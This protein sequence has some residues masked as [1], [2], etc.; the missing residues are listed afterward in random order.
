[1]LS[2]VLALSILA[3]TSFAAETC[4]EGTPAIKTCEST[5]EKGD[6]NV[7]GDVF[8][9]I[10][11]CSG[12]NPALVLIKNGQGEVAAATVEQRMGGATYTVEAAPYRFDF[13]FAQAT[14]P[15]YPTSP[16]KLAIT[17]DHFG[18]L[19]PSTYTCRR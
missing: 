10:I 14:N 15:M 13:S 18:Q 16:G 17:L 8:E 2:L 6:G 1:M 12:A 9:K 4:P 3:P 7:A 11:V 19:P 5:P